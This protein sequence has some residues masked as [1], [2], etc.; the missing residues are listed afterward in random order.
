[1]LR[2]LEKREIDQ[3]RAEQER[4][5]NN[6][7]AKL[8]KKV[9]QVRELAAETKVAYE[10]YRENALRA[11]EAELTPLYEERDKLKSDIKEKKAEWAVLLEPLDKQFALYVKTERGNIEAE[12][13]RQA[14]EAERIN[15]K[16]LE[17]EEVAVSQRKQ[18]QKNESE[19]IEA[20]K[21]RQAA[22]ALIQ[23]AKLALAEAKN[24]AASIIESAEQQA[25]ASQKQAQETAIKAQEVQNRSNALDSREK[26]LET[27]EMAVILKELQYYSPVK[28][29]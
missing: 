8:A 6:E 13:A 5:R 20:E 16:S 12:Q 4:A 15:R 18:A 26:E 25:L 23:G 11:I 27:R 10:K 28:K 24:R 3:K 7:G 21:M 19:R 1:M 14:I 9:E 29:N 17:Q 2:L 22:D